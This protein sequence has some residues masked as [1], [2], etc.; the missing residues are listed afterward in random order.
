[1]KERALVPRPRAREASRV[2][3][4]VVPLI[5]HLCPRVRQ[6]I[7]SNARIIPRCSSDRNLGGPSVNQ[8][9]DQ[10]RVHEWRRLY[11]RDPPRALSR[12]PLI[13]APVSDLHG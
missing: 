7:S 11:V 3:I 1:M 6:R 13:D 5:A 8:D 2:P 9:I 12:E 4:S 10:L